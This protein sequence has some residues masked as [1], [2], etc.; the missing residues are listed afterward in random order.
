VDRPFDRIAAALDYPM[1]V[2]SAAVGSDRD[3]CLVGFATQC[4][5]DPARYLV[6]LSKRNRTYEIARRTPTLV[7]H[8]LHEGDE[9]FARH[10]G[11]E[12]EKPSS[13]SGTHVADKLA[14]CPWSPGPGG[15]PVFGGLDW[16]AGNVID[17]I[18]LGDHVGVLVE[19]DDSGEA[20]RAEEP[21]VGF[22]ALRDLDPGQDP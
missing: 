13:G 4:S 9:V 20:G 10:F 14:G 18:E 12:S 11:E 2:V 6:C 3:A 15:A 21:L 1:Y 22:Q 5:I 16:F 17:R 7:V 19:V 8:V